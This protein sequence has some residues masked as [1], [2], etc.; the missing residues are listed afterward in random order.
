MAMEIRE[1]RE[2]ELE[3]VALVTSIAF[4]GDRDPE[5][6]LKRLDLYR[7]MSPIACLE[8][9]RVV[10]ALAVLPLTA[11]YEGAAIG[12]GGIAS[13]AC[14]PEERR[15][16]LVGRLL[17]Y[18]LDYMRQRG[19]ALSGLYTPHPSLYRRYGWSVA[20]RVLRYSFNPKD[21]RVRW[22]ERPRGRP[23]RIA[24][25]DWP[26][27]DSLYQE[28][29]QTR[30]GYLQRSESWWRQ[31]VLRGLYDAKRRLNDAA[32]WYDDRGEATG[33]LVYSSRQVRD[34]SGAPEGSTF[35]VRD[36]VWLN[37]NAYAGLLRYIL[38][39]DLATQVIMFA[40]ADDPLLSVIDEA[41][42]VDVKTHYGMMLRIVDV[43]KA[44][45][46]RPTPVTEGLSLSLAV[47]DDAAPWN[48]GTWRLEAADKR[49]DV[50]RSDAA[51]DLSCDVGHLAPVFNGYL[52]PSEAACAGLLAV[53]N[54]DAVQKADRIFAVS[55]PPAVADAF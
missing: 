27:L 19:M 22:L 39:F 38:S 35:S 42:R 21:I 18:S 49:M 7:L 30:N 17:T 44:L 4:D 34:A 2:E 54:V 26:V 50:R 15:R 20:H 33:Y 46:E 29:L 25:D 11:V 6:I 36:F 8:D 51:P 53:H 3:E 37:G 47:R 24:E 14:L 41:Q 55:Y 45:S 28:R 12:L 9:G 10:A 16:G 5:T 31:A 23:R 43:E 1:P 32:V 40:D 52:K 13:A 48:D